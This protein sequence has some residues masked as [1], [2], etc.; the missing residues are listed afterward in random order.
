MEAAARWFAEV[1]AR[2]SR[3]DPESELSRL[4]AHPGEPVVVSPLLF[5]ALRFALE[6]A[7]ETGG[8][9]DPTVGDALVRSGFATNYRTGR[10]V[11]AQSGSPV[12]FRDVVL[13]PASLEVTLLRPLTLDL[14]A[15]AK[16]LAIDLSGREL[17]GLPG[18]VIDAGGDILASGVDASG[19]PWVLG[20]RHPLVDAGL[21]ENLRP[22]GMALCTSGN[23]ERP[24]SN[25]GHI[26]E[27]GSGQVVDAIVSVSV[28][29][30]TAM[31][32]DAFATAAFVLGP[33][34][35]LAFLERQGA[36]G[37]ILTNSLERFDTAGLKE[38]IA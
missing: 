33:R 32:A 17:A 9:F 20:V 35:G 21:I 14:G 23:Y 22:A 7:A 25:G 4:C 34:D 10:A 2:C 16:G 11:E 30:P 6:V 26:I 27:P 24:G 12:S 8:A 31:A 5:E 37:L 29:A 36:E 19:E 15:V 1:E 38:F 13:A 3:F 28:L 18:F